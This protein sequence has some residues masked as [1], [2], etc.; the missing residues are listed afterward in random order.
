M[1]S[2]FS[3]ST[4]SS[5]ASSFQPV[6]PVAGFGDIME[7]RFSEKFASIPLERYK[8]EMA[9]AREALGE[10]GQMK[11]DE[12]MYDYYRD[13][14]RDAA[15]QGKINTLMR[16]AQAGGG[17]AASQLSLPTKRDAMSQLLGFTQAGDALADSMGYRMAGSR[18]G[19]KAAIAGFPKEPAFD[20]QA[21]PLDT[22]ATVR[23]T[24]FTT[25]TAPPAEL[26][27][28]TATPATMELMKQFLQTLGGAS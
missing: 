22:G 25:P 24:Q 8:Q 18:A 13:R 11:R 21:G 19:L 4:A 20:D 12:R 1:F 5:Y 26:Q 28:V 6:R 7:D 10:K 16:L 23:A 2:L 17:F 3:P 15:R 14:D 9:F 27:D